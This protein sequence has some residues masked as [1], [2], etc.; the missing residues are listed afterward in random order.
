MS[1]T[2]PPAPDGVIAYLTVKDGEAAIDFYTRAFG[3]ALQYKAPAQDGKRLMHARLAL[4]HG[5]L[6]L[7][8]DF[9]EYAG[10][11]SQ[12]P[13]PAQPR[14]VILHMQVKD[15]DAT[16]AQAL[17]AGATAKMPPSDMFWGDRYAQLVDPFGHVW[18]LAHALKK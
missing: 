17:Q 11:K 9:P 12:A 13:D 7:S 8:D 2:P 1:D 10:G 18:S 15:C 4:N 3:A 14:G 6:M 5:T 16:Y